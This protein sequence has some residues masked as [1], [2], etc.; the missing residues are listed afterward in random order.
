[1]KKA[2]LHLIIIVCTACFLPGESYAQGQPVLSTPAHNNTG[3]V[4]N[5]SFTW[6]AFTNGYSYEIQLA[7]DASFTNIITTRSNLNITRFVPVSQLPAGNVYWRV[8]AKDEAGADVSNWSDTFTYVVAIPPRTY[9]IPAHATLQ[10]IKDTMRKAI[11]NTPAILAFTAGETY[12]LDGNISGLFAIDTA[13]INDLIIEGNNAQ[14]VIKNNAHVGFMRIQNSNR[15]TVRRLTVDWDPLP[16]SLLD[17]ISVNKTDST[18]LNVNVRLREVNGKMSPYYP[19]IYDNASFTDHWSWSYLIDTADP[20]SL[21][22]IDNNTFGIVPADITPL[23]CKGQPEYNIYHTGTTSGK[24]FAVGDV[25]SIVARD[26]V[27]PLLSTSNCVDFVCDSI[28]NYTSPIGCY[29]SYDGS[30][31]KILNCQSTLKDASRFV[32]ANADGVHCRAN[33]IGPW[34]ENSTFIG[35]ADDGVALYNKGIFV[36]SKV[37]NTTLLLTNNVF[38]NLK[39]GHI[40]RIFTPKT[41]KVMS[42]NFTVDTVYLQSGSYRVQFT[43][44]IPASDYDSLVDMGLTDLQQNVQLYNA[45]LRNERFMISNNRFTV[46]A[47]GAIIRAA[48]GMVENNQFY[49]CSSAGVALYN[50]PALWYNGLYSRD[51]WITNNDLRDC[52][53]DN[54]GADAGSI[55][56]RL[57]EID[58][59]GP[60]NYFIDKMSAWSLDH[61]NIRITNNTIKN[62]AQHGISLFNAANCTIKNNTFTSAMPGFYR[63]GTHYG[64][65][66][67]T[68]YGTSIISNN[69]TGDTRTPMTQIQRVNDTATTVVP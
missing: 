16:H 31:M 68:T 12:E 55:N 63:T 56:V 39:K 20:G 40:F 3:Y 64:I 54:L 11:T 61:A 18:V 29:Y 60:N 26:N 27:G 10:A 6:Q 8:K 1:M 35:N 57:N 14:I 33:A 41:G 13:N 69:F 48:K 15:V 17:V 53:F 37:S 67:N 42:T 7:T 45:S 24:Y 46:R 38:M 49:S 59:A 58:S 65:Y 22:K 23:A 21:K 36:K 32:S 9:T 25:L 51:V 34:V 2:I 28:T 43:P 5:P 30:D 44:A 52:A 66:I 19:A 62:F 4:R 50:E 47:R